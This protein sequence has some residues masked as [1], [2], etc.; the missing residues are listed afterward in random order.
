M[1]SCDVKIFLGHT[2]QVYKYNNVIVY[3]V[4]WQYD[5]GVSVCIIKIKNKETRGKT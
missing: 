3:I 5:D 2:R 4:R 1:T